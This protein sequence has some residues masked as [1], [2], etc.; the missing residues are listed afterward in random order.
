VDTSANNI[1]NNN[2]NNINNKFNLNKTVTSSSVSNTNTNTNTKSSN[3]NLDNNGTITNINTNNLITNSGNNNID[4]N[5]IVNFETNTDT[6]Y[7]NTIL[8]NLD[9]NL[10]SSSIDSILS[11]DKYWI[12][13]P[14][15][16]AKN[17]ISLIFSD[18]PVEVLISCI[19]GLNII[20]LFLVIMLIFCLG[21]NYLVNKELELSFLNKFFPEY[22]IIK[23]KNYIKY[24]INIY[25][26][27][28]IVNT[29]LII[30]VMV[31]TLIMSIYFLNLYITHLEY[32]STYYL[33]LINNIKK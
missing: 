1:N 20:T 14:N 4:N 3:S 11:I 32:I 9:S 12:L 18:N 24:I 26:K 30:L 27:S 13:S 28:L 2:I 29:I 25:S 33:E 5:S 7:Q 31:I 19:L 21:S 17:L 22:Y 16:N 8:D 15:D 6:D 10:I 23:I